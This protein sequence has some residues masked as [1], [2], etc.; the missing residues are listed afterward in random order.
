MGQF[1]EP[2]ELDKLNTKLETAEY[3]L[4]GFKETYDK[5]VNG[6][7]LTDS[8]GLNKAEDRDCYRLR[9]DKNKDLTKNGVYR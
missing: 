8:L 7:K 5:T 1:L 4:A 6:P 2:E 9:R 3:Q